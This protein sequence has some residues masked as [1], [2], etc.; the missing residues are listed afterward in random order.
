MHFGFLKFQ[1]YMNLLRAQVF[2][3]EHFIGGFLKICV[4]LQLLVTVFAVLHRGVV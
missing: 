1:K 4:Q 2:I 3:A